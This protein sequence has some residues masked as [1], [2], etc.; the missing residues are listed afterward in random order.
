MAE[1]QIPYEQ[2]LN[3]A[4]YMRTLAEVQAITQMAAQRAERMRAPL[5]GFAKIAGIPLDRA[6]LDICID[7]GPD[8]RGQVLVKWKDEDAR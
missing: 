6:D 3:L 1:K 5:E 4:I 8:K 7:K 2:A